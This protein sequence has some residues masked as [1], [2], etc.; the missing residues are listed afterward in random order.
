MDLIHFIGMAI[1]G[2]LAGWIAEWISPGK[3]PGGCIVTSLL[4]ICGGLLFQ[5]ISATFLSGALGSWHFIGAII[6]TIILL[7]LYRLIFGR[8]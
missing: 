2:L 8:N 4:G 6:G 5:W 7:A 1:F 3:H